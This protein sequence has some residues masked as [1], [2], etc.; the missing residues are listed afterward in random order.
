MDTADIRTLYEYNSW[1]N[2]R[3]LDCTAQLNRDQ[4]TAPTGMPSGSL[5][6]TLI[7]ILGAQWIWRQRIQGTS[8]TSFPKPMLEL[9]RS[10]DLQALLAL[11]REE[12]QEMMAFVGSLQDK[13]L[14]NNLSYAT[15]KGTPYESTL[16]HILAH[17]VNHGTQHRS[18]A[19]QYL[20]A[21]GCSP[22]DLDLILFL[23]TRQA[24]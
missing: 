4:L 18:E 7:H 5:F 21:C 19:A 20:T 10:P 11:W 8:P 23:R 24:R 2:D 14:E 22:G 3:I 16:W 6:E 17:V 12:R 15:T 9:E 1:A 13:D